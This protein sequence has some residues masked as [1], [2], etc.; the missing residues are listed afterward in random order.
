MASKQKIRSTKRDLFSRAQVKSIFQMAWRSGYIRKWFKEN[1]ESR[2]A[3]AEAR[4]GKSRRDC[5]K[6][7]EQTMTMYDY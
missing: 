5:K 2:K 6:D 4:N 3:M 7:F 1:G